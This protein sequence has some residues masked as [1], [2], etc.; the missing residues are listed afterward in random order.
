MSADARVA[1]IRAY[2]RV[3]TGRQ[4]A[5]GFGLDAQARRLIDYGDREDA[6]LVLYREEGVSGAKERRPALDRLLADLRPGDTVLVTSLDRL[7]R[8][9][10]HLLQ[11]FDLFDRKGVRLVSLRE[12]IDSATPAGRLL[13][14]LLAAVAEF[15]RELIM[16]RTAAGIAGRARKSG[17]PWG[18]PKWPWP[19]DDTGG[20]GD[21]SAADAAIY[22]RIFRMRTAQGMSKAGI[23]A[24][25]TRDGVPTATGGR[26][27]SPTVISRV[28]AGREGLG[29]FHHGGVWHRGNHS[30]LIDEA[31][32]AAAQTMDEQGRKYAPGARGRLPKAHLFVRGMLRCS[33]GE[34]ML[35][36]TSRDQSDVYV[37]REHK[38]DSAS[39]PMPPLRRDRI[40]SAALRMF[41]EVA[42]DVEAT[43]LHLSGQLDA[44]A[45]E[46]NALVARAEHE[47]SAAVER[48][49]R[50]Q[51]A[52][53]DGVIEADDWADQRNGLV[54]ERE[55]ANA[56]LARLQA[57]AESVTATMA[58]VD[59]ENETLRRLADLRTAIAGRVNETA[60]GD[61]GALR[62][63]LSAVCAE[64]RLHGVDSDGTIVLDYHPVLSDGDDYW[65]RVGISFDVAA[66]N[67]KRPSTLRRLR[68]ASGDARAWDRIVRVGCHCVTAMADESEH[69]DLSVTVG[70][71]SFTGAGPAGRV[72]EALEKFAELVASADLD[73][74]AEPSGVEEGAPAADVTPAAPDEKEPLPVFLRSRTLK[75]NPETAAAIVAWA[76]KHDGKTQ[77]IRL[78]EIAAYWRGT[79]EKEPGN[80]GRDLGTAIKTGLLHRE[81][82]QYTVT[83][84]GKRSIGLSA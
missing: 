4:V 72:M 48:L 58:N 54:A 13:R 34:A 67:T 69:L 60:S 17:K 46:I 29:E 43:R 55:A 32:W 1:V 23:A 52:F 8:S 47:A 45:A 77:G 73:T 64:V 44:Q 33:C 10:K 78:S 49:Q 26:A 80:L 59:A 27:W 9:T 75:V 56:E 66:A 62:A 41:E 53:Q 3:S 21:P 37:C 38:R 40:D 51:R 65:Q 22:V 74:L 5:E 70:G 12:S 18:T 39:C 7:G 82:G 19:K 16:E 84:F 36:R 2:G 71:A 61:V 24:Q 50:V 14:T 25:L 63:A 42:L 15:E 6:E 30:P 57:N 35:P 68:G 81:N 20:W 79:T 31:T 76:Q 11:L 28:L 83:G